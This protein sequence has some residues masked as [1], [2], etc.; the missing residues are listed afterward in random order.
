MPAKGKPYHSFGW[1]SHPQPKYPPQNED[2][3]MTSYEV[4]VPSQPPTGIL[5]VRL[6][7][8]SRLAMPEPCDGSRYQPV[9]TG[10]NPWLVYAVMEYEQFQISAESEYCYNG[11]VWWSKP[12]TGYRGSNWGWYMYKFEVS[13]TSSELAVRMFARRSD[14]EAG[15]QTVSLGSVM[16]HPFM[17]NRPRNRHGYA[18][19][20]VQGGTGK[21]SIDISYLEKKVPPLSDTEVWCV[22]GEMGLGDLVYVEKLDT[23]RS[24]GMKTVPMAVDVTPESKLTHRVEHPFIA[25]IKFAFKS[26]KG[27]SLLSPLASGGPLYHHLQRARR[28]DVGLARFYAAELLCVLEYLHAKHIVLAHLNMEDVFLDSLG[29]LSLCNPSIFSLEVNDSNKIVPGTSA[30]PAPELASRNQVVSQTADWWAFGIFLYEMLTGL[31]PFYD[32]D[33]NKRRLNICKDPVRPGGLPPIAKDILIK[34]LEKDP[35]NRLGGKNGASEIK[36]HPFFENTNWHDLLQRKYIT[37]FKPHDAAT[38]FWPGMS[39]YDSDRERRV[40][41]KIENGKVYQRVVGA[42]WPRCEWNQTGWVRDGSAED[43]SDRPS[44]STTED[45]DDGWELV[46]DPTSYRFN[47]RNRFTDETSP[48]RLPDK[49]SRSYLW[50]IPREPP[51][52]PPAAS[53]PACRPPPLGERKAALEATLVAGYG[54]RVFSQILGH[55]NDLSLDFPILAYNQ[56]CRAKEG[57]LNSDGYFHEVQLTPLEWAVEHSRL[58]LVNLFLAHGADANYT[59]EWAEGPALVKAVRLG[60]L[61]LVEALVQK[62]NRVSRTRALLLAVKQQHN[63]IVNTL[64]ANGVQCDFE[65]SDRPLPDRRFFSDHDTTPDQPTALQ[66]ERFAPPLLLAVTS[67]NADLVKALLAHGADPNAPY[68]GIRGLRRDHGGSGLK[69]AA[70]FTCGRVIQLAM[71]YWQHSEI[72]QLL[73]DAGADVSLPHPVWPVPVWP[74]GGHVCEPVSRAVYLEV[75]AGLEAAMALRKRQREC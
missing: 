11:R 52:V 74:V 37:P 48:G 50:G 73:L 57:I 75:T 45:Y 35:L 14:A 47:F 43:D 15:L 71:E 68:H 13:N 60:S 3:T 12:R 42:P 69:V 9:G 7:P 54:V 6:H 36:D 58:D 51:A 30:Y 33:A 70:S 2:V 64:L 29:H 39:E 18:P 62:T 67:G 20:P 10:N 22:H 66:A 21:V 19:I 49:F 25:P 24:Y 38:E 34:L 16:V 65:E 27:L 59:V 26:S 31:P 17:E 53:D 55:G 46:W 44:A 32:Q 63:A 4:V 41:E 23:N 61:R 8:A 56:P 72:D 5:S 1:C 28:F 40:E